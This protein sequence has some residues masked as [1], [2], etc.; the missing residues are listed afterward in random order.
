[1]VASNDG[2]G[3]PGAGGLADG[4]MVKSRCLGRGGAGE[5]DSASGQNG[6]SAHL[7][8]SSASSGP[9][10]TPARAQSRRACL[11]CI[12]MMAEWWVSGQCVLSEVYRTS[13]V[14]YC[15]SSSYY[16]IYGEAVMFITLS[17]VISL[18]LDAFPGSYF[19]DRHVYYQPFINIGICHNT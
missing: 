2:S 4:D 1:M 11:V 7:F 5:Q 6:E 15:V 3:S 14:T 17:S 16:D 8:S 12:A 13:F 9:L 10:K 19:L 18:I